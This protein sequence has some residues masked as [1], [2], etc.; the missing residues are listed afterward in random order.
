MTLID[1]K[2]E[3][4]ILD[5]ITSNLTEL[6]K[7]SYGKPNHGITEYDLV[8]HAGHNVARGYFEHLP[9]AEM[10]D[11]LEDLERKG[12]LRVVEERVVGENQ[13]KLKFYIPMSL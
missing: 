4:E 12:R 2:T 5:F 6:L 9:A 10:R 1:V 7:P 11:Y 3:R 8:G 13:P